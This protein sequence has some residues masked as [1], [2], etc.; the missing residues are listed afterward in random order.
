MV[1]SGNHIQY[2][3]FM[4]LTLV[5]ILIFV[6]FSANVYADYFYCNIP[7]SSNDVLVYEVTRKSV[8]AIKLIQNSKAIKEK[9][10]GLSGEIISNNKT[11]L[12][13][14]TKMPQK[15]TLDRVSGILI[16]T[17]EGNSGGMRAVCFKGKDL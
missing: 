5:S 11:E 7:E 3:I 10:S 12:I 1:Y 6:F 9:L 13:W 2:N 8:N 15:Y 4:R 14:E 17:E 16:I